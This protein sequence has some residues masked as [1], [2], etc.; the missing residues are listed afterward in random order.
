MNKNKQFDEAQASL[1]HSQALLELLNPRQQPA[2]APQPT[3]STESTQPPQPPQQQEPT[4]QETPPPVEAAPPQEAP[5]DTEKALKDEA[6]N[7]KELTQKVVD[8]TDV[9]K[10]GVESLTSAVKEIAPAKSK[11]RNKLK[12]MIDKHGNK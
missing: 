1:A 3:E 5:V 9:L 2:Q 4:P 7:V 12:G 6:V 10:Q 11:L 8:A